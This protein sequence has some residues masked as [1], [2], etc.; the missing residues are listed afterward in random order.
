MERLHRVLA[1]A[2]VAS[3]RRAEDLIVAGRVQVNGQV[4]GTLGVKI[5]PQHDVVE[6]DRQRI[7]L[8]SKTYLVLNKPR[9]YISDRDET[10]EN[11]TALDLVPMHERLFAAGR[12]D[13]NSEGLLLLTNDGDLTFRLTHPRFEHQKEY[14][15]L[16]SGNPDNATLEKLVRGIRYQ[17]EWLKADRAVHAARK[18]PF[19]EAGREQSWLRL[20]LHE[21]KKRQIRHMCGAVGYPVLR[22]IRIRIGPIELDGLKSGQWRRLTSRE[23]EQLR[24]GAGK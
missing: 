11:K 10:G 15:A 12:L 4:V 8:E 13:V 6:V 3:R 18:Q 5:D 14:L 22:L 19:G 9:G 2:G 16:V 7:H 21:G 20:T 1:Q 24:G 17:E 23:I